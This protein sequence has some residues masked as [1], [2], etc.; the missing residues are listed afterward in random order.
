MLFVAA[1]H[2]ELFVLFVATP[3]NTL[4]TLATLDHA[5]SHRYRGGVCCD[6]CLLVWWLCA[7]A[8]LLYVLLN[9]SRFCWLRTGRAA[10]EVCTNSFV[11]LFDLFELF[12]LRCAPVVGEHSPQDWKQGTPAVAH[13]IARFTRRRCTARHGTIQHHATATSAQRVVEKE[14][15]R[16]HARESSAPNNHTTERRREPPTNR[17]GRSLAPTD[18]RQNARV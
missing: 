18:V 10:D 9:R 8:C 6:L 17:L 14:R 13:R 12:C 4:A 3:T 1:V 5:G 11:L 16:A 7:C 2:V 15:K